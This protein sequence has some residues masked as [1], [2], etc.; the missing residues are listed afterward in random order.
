L[1]ANASAVIIN[2]A[3]F[4]VNN[5]SNLF[6]KTLG[7]KTIDSKWVAFKQPYIELVIDLKKQ[8]S[9]DSISATFMHNPSFKVQLPESV[10]YSVSDN[11]NNFTDI[12]IAKNIWAGLG[13]KEELKTFAVKAPVNTTIR[14]IKLSFK[15]VNSPNITGDDLPQSMLCDEVI[16][17]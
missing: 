1:A 15:M 7:N 4:S 3:L 14:Y 17:Q 12:G 5:L 13:I 16:V 9:I 6:D 11:G 2:P 10:K 8:V